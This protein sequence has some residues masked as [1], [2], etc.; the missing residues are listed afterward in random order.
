MLLIFETV[1]ETSFEFFNIL[2][3]FKSKSSNK[4]Q[5]EIEFEFKIMQSKSNR[6]PPNSISV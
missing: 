5:V 6:N 1:I 4:F 3:F 2:V